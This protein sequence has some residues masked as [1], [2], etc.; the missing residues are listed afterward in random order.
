MLDHYTQAMREEEG[1]FE[2]PMVRQRDLDRA[3]VGP[4]RRS[5]RRR[6]AV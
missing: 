4:S 3:G 6:V 5:R 2:G 1:A